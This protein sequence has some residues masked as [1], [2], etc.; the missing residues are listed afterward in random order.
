LEAIASLTGVD[1]LREL[2]TKIA[3]Y[4]RVYQSTANVLN[5]TRDLFDSARSVAEDT[6]QNT[7]KIGN[8]LLD[9][10][11]VLEDSYE[12]MVD[13]Y[14]PQSR[15]MRKLDRFRDGLETVEQGVS[16]IEQIASDVVSTQESYT[17]LKEAKKEW[18]DANTKLLA[19]KKI[20]KDATKLE[21]QVTAEVDGVDFGKDDTE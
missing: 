4:N 6:A 1:T 3:K 8:S 10:G 21:S 13:K 16:S 15:A 19:D 7:G 18:A 11:V 12:R 9:S 2:T 17:E 5:A 20:T 14:S